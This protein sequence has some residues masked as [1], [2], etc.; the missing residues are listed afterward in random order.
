ISVLAQTGNDMLI[1]DLLEQTS[2]GHPPS[3]AL[4]VSMRLDL[5][6]ANLCQSCRQVKQFGPNITYVMEARYL[7][8]RGD[9][10]AERE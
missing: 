4:C 3:P 8:R 5:I 1:P 2:A 7:P 9:S 10:H 6:G